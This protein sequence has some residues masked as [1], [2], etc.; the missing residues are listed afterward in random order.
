MTGFDFLHYF[1][2]K[3]Q[4]YEEQYILAQLIALSSFSDDTASLIIFYQFA[5][6]VSTLL[7]QRLAYIPIKMNGQINIDIS[8]GGAR[9]VLGELSPPPSRDF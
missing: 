8:S 3:V 6:V 4:P 9:G 2:N 1:V 5:R 7:P